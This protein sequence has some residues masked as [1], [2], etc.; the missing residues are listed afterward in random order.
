[1]LR[2]IACS[3][4][5]AAVI[6]C[7]C[8]AEPMWVKGNTHAHSTQSDGNVA[9]QAAADI[10]RNHGYQFLVLSDHNK[11]TDPAAITTPAEGF[12]LIP[13][14]EVT[15]GYGPA[16]IHVNAIGVS[17]VIPPVTGTSRLDTLRR[18]IDAIAQTGALAQINHPN[19][20]YA[21]GYR[22][23]SRRS[24]CSLFELCNAGGGCNNA[25]DATHP[26]LETVWDQ[27]LTD[28]QTVYGVASDDT[29]NYNKFA[30]GSD[31][32]GNGWIM[33]RVNK[34]TQAEVLAGIASGDF[35]A[36]T[37]VELQDVRFRGGTLSL[38]IKPTEGKTYSIAFI[39]FGGKVVSE[40]T[41][42]KASCE[43]ANA[44]NAYLR[45]KVTASDGKV[46]WTQPF[47]ISK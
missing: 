15:A 17:K 7:P 30:S 6:C 27:M 1:M 26:S 13:G 40:A 16:P 14:E 29:H 39:G 44:P 28:G 10:Y 9:P 31:D 37:G 24:S 32:P 35:Y 46:A 3:I 36:S 41:G 2:K 8:A 43:I 11:L 12:I 23:L 42:L 4:I 5:L 45:A 21:L 38:S 18:N 33:V 47:R 19:W 22:E 34:L 25:G 20:H